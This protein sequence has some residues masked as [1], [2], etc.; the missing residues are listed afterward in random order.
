MNKRL[1]FIFIFFTLTIDAM[2]IG[3]IVP[4]MPDLLREISGGDLGNAAIWVGYWHPF[5]Q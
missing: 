1:A 2:G 3:L 4:V 5:L